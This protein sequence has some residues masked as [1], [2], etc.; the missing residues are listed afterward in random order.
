MI[1]ARSTNLVEPILI[2][3]PYGFLLS[4]IMCLQT[5]EK[6]FLRL[7]KT[8]VYPQYWLTAHLSASM[9]DI[10]IGT[11]FLQSHG[12]SGMQ[13]LGGNTHFTA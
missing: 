1:L 3:Y 10:F 9:N 4:R 12:A 11:Q 7:Q 2:F 6:P 8:C 13:L 5:T